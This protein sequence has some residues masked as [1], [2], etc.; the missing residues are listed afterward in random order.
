MKPLARCRHLHTGN[1]APQQFDPQ[2]LFQLLD[3]PAD[4]S[5]GHA[6]LLCRATEGA[7][8]GRPV[9]GLDIEVTVWSV[10]ATTPPETVSRIQPASDGAD[11]RKDGKRSFFDP[12]SGAYVEADVVLRKTMETG[13]RVNGPAALTEDETTI[14]VPK[15]RCAIRQPDGCIDVMKKEV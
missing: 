1:P 10:N 5:M 11:A 15:S 8:A 6:K 4:S 7:P 9:E 12:A 2:M 14:I 3:L 13:Q